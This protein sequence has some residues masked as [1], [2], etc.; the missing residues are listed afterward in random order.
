MGISFALTINELTS[1][2]KT[3]TRRA[4]Q[5]DYAKN[6]IRYFDKSIA[7]PALNKGRHRGGHEL[8]FIRL[9]QRPYQQYLSEM[10]ATDLQEEGG[11]VATAQGF[12]DTFF[13]GQDKLVWVLHFE[14]L[15]T[16]VNNNTD[17]L[18]EDN[19]RLREQLAKLEA[20]RDNLLIRVAEA[21]NR[22]IKVREQEVTPLEERL[23][24]FDSQLVETEKELRATKR[25]LG[26]A[27]Q[28]SRQQFFQQEILKI[29]LANESLQ[30]RL[31]E[32]ETAIEAIVNIP[33][34]Q[35]NIISEA[36]EFAELLI[37]NAASTI[38]PLEPEEFAELLIESAASTISP[39]ASAETTDFLLENTLD[40]NIVDASVDSTEA[41]NVDTDTDTVDIVEPQRETDYDDWSKWNASVAALNE[42]VDTALD[43]TIESFPQALLTAIS[44]REKKI[45]ATIDKK[46]YR[47]PK[48]KLTKK[49]ADAI[50]ANNLQRLKNSL[51]ELRDF[52]EL[53]IGQLVTKQF[54]PEI[55]G[56]ITGFEMSVG[57]MPLIWVVWL[58][59]EGGEQIAE[60]YPLKSLIV[61][62]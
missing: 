11:M 6:F 39:L 7:I 8:G 32:A 12:I 15:S 50:S 43:A 53:R 54:H 16:P 41:L 17:A 34:Q 35:I 14:F 57:G 25:E 56:R 44:D 37:E 47:Q 28:H 61:E 48:G 59:S 23:I 20:D 60:H 52:Q 29:T 30:I 46:E 33:H 26:L 62:S 58:Q 22:Y 18:T 51:Q 21:Q 5:D 4:W 27:V 10:S 13:E 31:E 42:A 49:E 19:R 45:H 24:C 36:E 55:K 38:S 3:Q 9:T 1:G 2:K 40:V